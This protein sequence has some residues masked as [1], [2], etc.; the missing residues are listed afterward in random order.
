MNEPDENRRP[1]RWLRQRIVGF[2]RLMALSMLVFT[3]G[4]PIEAD[5][6]GKRP[7]AT[8]KMRNGKQVGKASWYGPRFHG[9]K[10]ASGKRF[11]QH[12]LTAAHRRLP[13]G[14]R[15]KVTNLKNGKTVK[16]KINDRGPYHD[17]RIIDLSRAAAERLSMDGVTR[18]SIEVLN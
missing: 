13:L 4:V 9:K 7:T 16:V 2:S 5:A 15:V 14:T 10:T 3:V 8:A 1:A 18:V 11:N 17:G 12:A 6:G